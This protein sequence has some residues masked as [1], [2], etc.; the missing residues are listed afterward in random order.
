MTTTIREYSIN[1][2][3]DAVCNQYG[4][5]AKTTINFCR[6]CER[7]NNYNLI[8]KKFQKLVKTS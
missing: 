1:Q 7:S 3:I 6:L 4:F 5:E 8:R 2:M